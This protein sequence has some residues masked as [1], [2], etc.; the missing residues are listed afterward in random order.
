MQAAEISPSSVNLS[1]QSD[2]AIFG[3]GSLFAVGES[4]FTMRLYEPFRNGD[5]RPVVC[6]RR[7][8]FLLG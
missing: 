6:E 8:A 7:C 3:N 1:S 2:P 5:A 4:M